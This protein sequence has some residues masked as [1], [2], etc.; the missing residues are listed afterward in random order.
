MASGFKRVSLNVTA[1]HRP[2]LTYQ[3]TANV[4]IISFNTSIINSSLSYNED[5]VINGRLIQQNNGCTRKADISACGLGE[6]TSLSMGF[7]FPICLRDGVG[8]ELERAIQHQHSVPWWLWCDLP[9]LTATVTFRAIWKRTCID[10]GSSSVNRFLAS[11]WH[12]RCGLSIVVP[13][14]HQHSS[15]PV[16][17]CWTLT[18]GFII[19]TSLNSPFR[20]QAG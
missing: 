17:V 14:S 5:F 9:S 6:G 7:R 8:R 2:N 16:N 12:S 15:W 18:Y 10:M 3:P 20:L 19:Y 1:A 4:L 13:S 11:R